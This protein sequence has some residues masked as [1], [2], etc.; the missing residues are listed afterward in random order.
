ME[1]E[2]KQINIPEIKLSESDVEVVAT[3]R[4]F[5]GAAKISLGIVAIIVVLVLIFGLAIGIPGL[6]IYSKA[7][8]L[9][10][11]YA[12]IKAAISKQNILQIKTATTKLQTDLNS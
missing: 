9:N 6:T 8:V 12:G 3:P 11:D 2:I 1:T 10:A 4:S 5:R 7:K